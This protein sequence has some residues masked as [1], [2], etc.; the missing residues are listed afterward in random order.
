[1]RMGWV[2]SQNE[3][4]PRARPAVK[5]LF[6][7]PR[8]VSSRGSK[9][10][11]TQ[12]DFHPVRDKIRQ[13][14]LSDNMKITLHFKQVKYCFVV[15]WFMMLFTNLYNHFNWKKK[16]MFSSK[17]HASRVMFTWSLAIFHRSAEQ[18][19]QIKSSPDE[20]IS[21]QNQTYQTPRTTSCTDDWVSTRDEN[22]HV[23]WNNWFSRFD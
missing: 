9:S 10:H 8:V 16:M 4:L 6:G 21:P 22:T 7:L 23:N 14:I 18:W 2:S 11:L 15:P 20:H 5:F 17:F 3:P 13:S 19:D 1:M 12:D